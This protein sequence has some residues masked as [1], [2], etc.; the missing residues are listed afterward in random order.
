MICLAHVDDL[1]GR[2][3]F[4]S[5]SLRHYVILI[6]PAYLRLKL[7]TRIA[8]CVGN[9]GKFVCVGLNYADHAAE[10]GMD[11]PDEPVIFFQGHLIYNG[12]K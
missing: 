10:S 5:Y 9:V 8:A 12:G 7:S 3:P 1:V 6:L 11:L 2:Y 4:R